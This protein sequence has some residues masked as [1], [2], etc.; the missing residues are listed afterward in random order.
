MYARRILE[1]ESVVYSQDDTMYV[2][3]KKIKMVMRIKLKY[4]TC[5]TNAIHVISPKKTHMTIPTILIDG[6]GFVFRAY[7]VQPPLTSPCGQP[8]GALFGMT[9][10]L[11]KLINDFHPTKCAMVFDSGG[12]NH[13]HELY[14]EYKAHRPPL[15]EDLRLQLPL[16]RDLATAL[17]F[18]ILEK[19]NTEADDIIATIATKLAKKGEKVIIISSDKDLMQ[20]INDQIQMYDPLK[21]KYIDE[22]AVREKFGLGPDK[23]R[24]A[25]ALIGDSSD[26][27]PGAPGI[28]PK[29]AAD[30][31]SQFGSLDGIFIGSAS[32]KQDKRRA[33]IQD[34]EALIRL[35]WDLVGLQYDVEIENNGALN[36]H[37]PDRD[38]LARFLTQY[39][40]K[41]LITRAEKLFGLDLEHQN[42]HCDEP[43]TG[44]QPHQLDPIL[45]HTITS[46]SELQDL[47]NLATE[48]GILALCINNEEK[49]RLAVD[50][51]KS[52][53]LYL[54]MAKADTQG[55][56]FT[57]ARNQV[58]LK[59][60]WNIIADASVKKITYD[61][62]RFWYCI[63]HQHRGV[64][65]ED[66]ALMH[67]SYT[68]G[69]PQLSTHDFIVQNNISSFIAI[70][71]SYQQELKLHKAFFLY[72]D[73]DLPLAAI[74]YKMERSGVKID[75]A[76]LAVMSQKFDEEIKL[77]EH[78]IH[79]IAGEEFNIGSP[80]QLGE[81]LF[82][83][84][85]LKSSK[86]SIK[87]K[88]YSTSAEVLETL[89]E[90]GF[91]I[92]DLVLR[93][94]EISKLKNT[95]TDSLPKKIDY[96][97]GRVHTNFV[98]NLTSTGRLSSVEPN[99][100]NI[101]IRTKEGALIRTAFVAAPGYKLI[102]A[103]YSQIELR[104]LAHVANVPNL[105]QA[106]RNGEDIHTTTAAQVF[107]IAK[108]NITSELRR[109]AKAVNFGMI[110]GISAFGLAKQLGIG[111]K[112]AAEIQEKY[113]KEYP[114]IKDYMEETREFAKTHGYVTNM[115]G[116]KC[117]LP[118]IND[119]NF[120]MRSFSERA[121]INAPLQGANAD[122][123]KLA[124]IEIDKKFS[125]LNLKTKMIL[126]V[127]DELIFE[128][129][130]DEIDTVVD[131]VRTI[132]QNIVVLE[133][134][135]VVDVGI[136]DNWADT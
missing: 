68:A 84:M 3:N 50:E 111:R 109:K 132:M 18:P 102:S 17:G 82:E 62:K 29:G 40:F 65:F 125:M 32:I 106:F 67:Y 129:P 48:K 52:Y 83:K 115:F 90:G 41:T 131:L 79:A 112:E 15:P 134:P 122:I 69:T 25:L 103:D 123:I 91:E 60:L 46:T 4:V 6:Y 110:Y 14:S 20:L 11:M 133:V 117:I 98:Q 35:S 73:I 107:S 135:L 113:F 128:T 44:L 63:E 31:I 53:I 64:A 21:G 76:K 43:R 78:K 70:Y 30:L 55:D 130:D 85:N 80:K 124:M 38:T 57:E 23:V 116:R 59:A 120:A 108:E 58:D 56:L 26:N 75:Q 61:V 93:W 77:L 33:I 45:E 2:T 74:L 105:R 54:E 92:A 34:N 7:H 86:I 10:M 89:S 101:P 51:K 8:V 19:P 27:I 66:L 72:Y 114:G 71:H 127:H 39:G 118:M 119:K 88:T 22:N 12:K 16:I 81:V 5:T 36:W 9:S 24:D 104:I 37:R 100:Q 13:R 1:L 96:K 87:S 136:G 121:A 95:Y 126:Q 47:L 94:R 28:G 49:L 42:R 99:L 97:T